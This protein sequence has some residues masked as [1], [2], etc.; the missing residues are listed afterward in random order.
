MESIIK[1]RNTPEVSNF[2]VFG[3]IIINLFVPYSDNSLTIKINPYVTDYK[4]NLDQPGIKVRHLTIMTET[5]DTITLSL[6]FGNNNI[7]NFEVVG[8]QYQIKLLDIG[9][10]RFEN[11]DFPYFELLVRTL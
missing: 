3:E 5:E 2:E 8:Q 4:E 6:D 9:K 7:Q 1:L 11:Q 10:E